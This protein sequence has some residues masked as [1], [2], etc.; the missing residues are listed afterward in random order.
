[1]AVLKEGAVVEAH[2]EVVVR[3][4]ELLGLPGNERGK[5][6]T[7]RAEGIITGN[8]DMIEN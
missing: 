6:R 5:R 3:V 8:E 1:M 7:R 4:E 2:V